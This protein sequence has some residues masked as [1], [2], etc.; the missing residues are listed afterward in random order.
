MIE[1]RD[2][3]PSLLKKRS[4]STSPSKRMKKQAELASYGTLKGEALLHADNNSA[5]FSKPTN[6]PAPRGNGA[7]PQSA[8][9]GQYSEY[10]QPLPKIPMQ[11]SSSNGTARFPPAIPLRRRAESSGDRSTGELSTV[12]GASG[13][14]RLQRSS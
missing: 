5:S 4:P 9:F 14:N 7:T 11:Q 8:D 13:A 1:T 6:G 2:S 10:Q 12:S 3:Y